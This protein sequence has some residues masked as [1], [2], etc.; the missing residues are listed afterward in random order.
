MS[1]IKDQLD[2]QKILDKI[3]LII[4]NPAASDKE[5]ELLQKAKSEI[6]KG[7]KLESHL[8]DLRNWLLPLVASHKISEDGLALYKILRADR[9]VGMNEGINLI[10]G[11][12]EEP[13]K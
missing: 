4:D 2:P 13:F 12:L 8:I 9:Q 1:N 5:K 11:T 3:N 6:D 10:K 7:G